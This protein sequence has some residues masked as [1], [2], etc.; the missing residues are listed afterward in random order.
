M[1]QL[2]GK[3]PYAAAAGAANRVGSEA[4]R[5]EERAAIEIDGPSLALRLSQFRTELRLLPLDAGP[6]IEI[7]S[8]AIKKSGMARGG[9]AAPSR[10]T[11]VARYRPSGVR[12]PI[13]LSRTCW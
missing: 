12:T 4:S 6:D 3:Q 1:S 5:G 10:A 2:E 13:Q 7:G 9:P 11:A 8:R